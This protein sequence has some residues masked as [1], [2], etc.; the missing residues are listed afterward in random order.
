VWVWRG[1]AWAVLSLSPARAE[2]E[3]QDTG[4]EQGT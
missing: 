4:D 2:E 3:K 1:T